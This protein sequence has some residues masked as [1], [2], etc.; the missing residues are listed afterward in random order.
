M[1]QVEPVQVPLN[2]GDHRMGRLPEI[3]SGGSRCMVSWFFTV[4]TT[5]DTQPVNITTLIASNFQHPSMETGAAGATMHDDLRRVCITHR[6]RRPASPM[7]R[8]SAGHPDIKT[9]LE[10]HISLR[11]RD[12]VEARQITARAVLSEP[13]KTQTGGNETG[14]STTSKT[15]TRY[16]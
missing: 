6:A 9:T 5:N 3:T 14:H 4:M 7:E 2:R 11:S 1:Q 12:M 13:R 16:R 15:D 10:F 8:K